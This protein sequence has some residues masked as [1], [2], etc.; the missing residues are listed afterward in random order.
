MS[1]IALRGFYKKGRV[2]HSNSYTVGG[3]KRELGFGIVQQ[4][5][6]ASAKVIVCGPK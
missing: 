2:F 5:R 6:S 1:L 4:P 3:I